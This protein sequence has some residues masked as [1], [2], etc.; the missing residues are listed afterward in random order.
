MKTWFTLFLLLWVMTGCKS[1]IQTSITDD[2]MQ[3]HILTKGIVSMQQEPTYKVIKSSAYPI[4]I[5]GEEER[6]I[7]HSD[8]AKEVEAFEEAYLALSDEIAPSF[9]GTMI[10]ASMGEKRSGGYRI[11]VESV[12]DAGRYTEVTLISHE[13]S[14][15]V[16]MALTN[17]YIVIYLPDNHKD[18][19][20][21]EK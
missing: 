4:M 8:D 17:P 21:I 18:I 19:K 14:G 3:S 1:G 11:E 6:H 15:L 20:I 2:E 16:T 12:K 13:P 7:Y 9:D 5:E 10:I